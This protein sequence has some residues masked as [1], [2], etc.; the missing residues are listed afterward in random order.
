MAQTEQ[1]LLYALRS[2]TTP[3]TE[4]VQRA[5]AA[6]D[7]APKSHT[8][9]PLVRDWTFDILLKATRI[10]SL[11]EALSDADLW[12]LAARTTLATPSLNLTAPALPIFVAFI[13]RCAT[14]RPGAAALR[15][16]AQVWARIAVVAMRKATVD[17]GLDSY[18]KLLQASLHVYRE[19]GSTSAEE[20][21]C[22][23]GLAVSWLGA[24]RAVVLEAGKGGK[25]VG[26]IGW[27]AACPLN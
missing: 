22:W 20:R 14:Q 25:K 11:A 26:L 27:R 17:A 3:L 1:A 9:P 5:S 2:P 21:E 10:Q 4:K 6:L 8:L 23:E 24:L 12:A 18:E 13:S 19:E 15:S 7:A 16:V